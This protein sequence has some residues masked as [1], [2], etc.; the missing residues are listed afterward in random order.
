MDITVG[1]PHVLGVEINEYRT[2]VVEMNYR[3]RAPRVYQ[4][5]DFETPTGTLEDGLVVQAGDF[6]DRLRVQLADRKIRTKRMVLSI[7]SS[8]ILEREVLVPQVKQSRL[9]DLLRLNASDYFPVNVSEYV[10][11]Y[12]IL[13]LV[14]EAGHRK[15][16]RLVVRAVPQDI[17]RSCNELAV[18]CGMQLVQV[19]Y[20]MNGML[21]T[22][23]AM[24]KSEGSSHGR[25]K[26]RVEEEEGPELKLYLQ[27]GEEYTRLILM[28]SMQ[29]VLQ[30]VVQ[31]PAEEEQEIVRSVS[32]I[33][34]F[35]LNRSGGREES[36]SVVL[37]GM[38][39]YD[40]L[41]LLLQDRLGAEVT[42]LQTADT[43][44]FPAGARMTGAELGDYAAVIGSC[45]HPL[46]LRV[47]SEVSGGN[48][49]SPLEFL[50]SDAVQTS[51]AMMLVAV[52]VICGMMGAYYMVASLRD[53]SDY[54]EA[55]LDQASQVAELNRRK[56]AKE[57]YE[58]AYAEYK[59][60]LEIGDYMNTANDYVVE[61]IEELESILPSDAEV[62]SISFSESGAA[63]ELQV[64]SWSSLAFT[65]IQFRDM[66]TA[67][68]MEDS[69]PTS[70]MD[71]G[72][73]TTETTESTAE[74]S[75]TDYSSWTVQQLR[76]EC[77]NRMETYPELL[78]LVMA[79][80]GVSMTTQELTDYV[81][82]QDRSNL[83]LA[84]QQSD[85]YIAS[86]ETEEEETDTTPE[87][88]YTLTAQFSYNFDVL[89]ITQYIE[90]GGL[91][92]ELGDEESSGE[93]TEETG[94][95]ASGEDA[96]EEAA[97]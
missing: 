21:Q 79:Q 83:I 62:T 76:S 60:M 88:L 84:L 93:T 11:S 4:F 37:M 15:Q 68:L 43:R 26:K 78:N 20:A 40:Y 66:E 51:F 48:E 5:F 94:E 35:Y 56:T 95:D 63:V 49:F 89:P 1:T 77:I 92:F 10:L 22:L 54:E 8:R 33:L 3:S 90:G 73:S 97:E 6:A 2:R 13:E 39:E 64:T 24:E 7:M 47:K 12:D 18:A 36:F 87:H 71:T 81:N 9:K 30:R 55:I 67:T 82:A 28:K 72:S 70:Y 85:S 27:P 53:Y 34:D 23:L 59:S 17:L 65:I 80:N 45:I 31:H 25:K 86:Q 42:M 91:T 29:P 58:A 50:L 38:E 57:E 61:F 44:A 69:L 46:G 16:Y 14:E 74:S 19:D 32:R 75:A 52:G 96:G 41:Q